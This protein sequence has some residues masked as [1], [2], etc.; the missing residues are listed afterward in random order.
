MSGHLRALPSR[1]WGTVCNASSPGISDATKHRA[2]D[3]T[4]VTAVVN[5]LKSEDTKQVAVHFNHSLGHL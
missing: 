5:A 3:V 2:P 4:N 1:G